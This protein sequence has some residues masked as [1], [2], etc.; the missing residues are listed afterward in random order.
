M[1]ASLNS[2]ELGTVFACGITCEHCCQGT[3]VLWKWQSGWISRVVLRMII[4][5]SEC[6]YC[7]YVRGSNLKLVQDIC[8]QV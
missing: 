7:E 4:V 2:W 3:V 5:I 6:L 8:V 1:L